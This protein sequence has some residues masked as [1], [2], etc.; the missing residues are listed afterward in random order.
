MVLATPVTPP[1]AARS[2]G[3]TTAITYDCRA[4]TSIWLMLKR[5]RSTA[6]ADHND[7][8]SGTRIRRTFDGGE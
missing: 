2:P 7:G 3:V 4:G 5:T 1:A 6:T 8:I